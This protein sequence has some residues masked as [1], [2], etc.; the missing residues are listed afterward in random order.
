MALRAGAKA[1]A[2]VGGAVAFHATAALL[3][4]WLLNRAPPGRSPSQEPHVATGAQPKLL[5]R[6]GCVFH[7][8]QCRRHTALAL[9]RPLV[10]NRAR[11]C[12]NRRSDRDV[13]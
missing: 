10:H 6:G 4:L 13:F 11:R 1:W 9:G 7:A 12:R 2:A 5:W 8:G 3:A